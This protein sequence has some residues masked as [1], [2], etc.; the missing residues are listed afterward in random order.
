MYIATVTTKRGR[1]LARGF[2]VKKRMKQ[3]GKIKGVIIEKG[4]RLP[5]GENEKLFKMEVG[6]ITRNNVPLN[7]FHWKD[8]KDQHKAPLFQKIKVGYIK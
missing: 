8:M 6:V 3:D 7:I 1:G 4:K 5:V 2:E